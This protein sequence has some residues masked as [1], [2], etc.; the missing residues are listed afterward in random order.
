MYF[1]NSGN[2]REPIFIKDI[3][4][5]PGVLR[6]LVA[7]LKLRLFVFSNFFLILTWSIYTGSSVVFIMF[8][9]SEEGRWCISQGPLE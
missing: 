2:R 6:I 4:K 5:T 7:C 9:K 1:W 8:C 3:S